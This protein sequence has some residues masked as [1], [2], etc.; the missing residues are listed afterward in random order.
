MRQLLEAEQSRRLTAEEA[1]RAR[2]LSWE[3]EG[4]RHELLAVRD[5][6]EQVVT[7]PA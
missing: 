6:F 2:T 5:Q 1:A 4:L 7:Q 3:A